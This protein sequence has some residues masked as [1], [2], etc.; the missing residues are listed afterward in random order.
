MKRTSLYERI[1]SFKTRIKFLE[2]Q[3]AKLI[4][5]NLLSIKQIDILSMKIRVLEAKLKEYTDGNTNIRPN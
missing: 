4:S 5:D 2:D 3:N 1:E